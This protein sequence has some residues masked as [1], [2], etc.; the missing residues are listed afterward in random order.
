MRAKQH[1]HPCPECD[2]RRF[3]CYCKQIPPKAQAM[4][5]PCKMKLRKRYDRVLERMVAGMY[6]G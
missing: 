1:W 2:G 3:V 5:E 4:C 6:Q